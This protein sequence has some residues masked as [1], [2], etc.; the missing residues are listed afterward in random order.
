MQPQQP[1]VQ[2][3]DRRELRR[4]MQGVTPDEVTRGM[5]RMDPFGNPGANLSELSVGQTKD[6]Q[7]GKIDARN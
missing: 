4:P 7:D 3:Q 5:A 6:G 2:G 1:P